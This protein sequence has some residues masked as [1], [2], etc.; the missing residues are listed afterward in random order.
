MLP[1]MEASY[2]VTVIDIELKLVEE[3]KGGVINSNRKNGPTQK[4]RDRVTI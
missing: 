4:P 3:E 2:R 1:D